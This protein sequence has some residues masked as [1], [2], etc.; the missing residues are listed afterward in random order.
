[1]PPSRPKKPGNAH[2]AIWVTKIVNDPNAVPLRVAMAALSN[3][4]SYADLIDQ[5]N[6]DGK[7]INA[8]G[9]VISQSALEGLDQFYDAF[10]AFTSKFS[11][12]HPHI[13]FELISAV[14][15]MFEVSPESIGKKHLLSVSESLANVAQSAQRSGNEALARKLSGLSLVY[16]ETLLAAGAPDSFTARG[17]AKAFTIAGAPMRA[18]QILTAVPAGHVNH[19]LLYRRAEAELALELPQSL[20]TARDA[21]AGA[22]SDPRATKN[23][24]TYFD[25]LSRCLKHVG[26]IHNALEQANLAVKHSDDGQFRQELTERLNALE[27]LILR[28]SPR[29]A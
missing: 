17:L 24:A 19:W 25:M 16:A 13:T 26:D 7:S 5:L 12:Q 10:F 29:Q 1:M 21:L 4:R 28:Q 15:D 6:A 9:E 14:G 11:Y 8:L 2:C 3:L 23:L 18:L 22:Q 20:E 27:V